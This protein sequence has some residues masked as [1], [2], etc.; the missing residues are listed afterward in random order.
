M[1]IFIAFLININFDVG[2]FKV[3]NKTF[4]KQRRLVRIQDQ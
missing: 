2:L 1:I 3:A 4:L